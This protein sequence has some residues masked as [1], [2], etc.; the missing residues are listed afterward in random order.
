MQSLTKSVSPKAK[1]LK[2]HFLV[3]KI[4]MTSKHLQTS[5]QPSHDPSSE[6]VLS[7]DTRIHKGA[8]KTT[9]WRVRSLVPVTVVMSPWT[10]RGHL[11]WEKVVWPAGPIRFSCLGIG[12]Q[13]R[14]FVT[15]YKGKESE[16]NRYICMYN[17]ITLLYL[18][19]TQHGKSISIL[20]KPYALID[21]QSHTYI[22]WTH[23]Y[24]FMGGKKT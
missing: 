24:I 14:Y 17:W 23:V 6:N 19:L 15:T 1:S 4:R 20:K 18:K 11:S 16:K 5:S 2:C 3:Y 8:S 7:H 13:D 22:H 12:N 21:T 10:K 9:R